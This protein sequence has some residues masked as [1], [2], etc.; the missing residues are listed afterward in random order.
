MATKRKTSLKKWICTV[1]NFIDL[2]QFHLIW[3]FFAKLSG[4]ESE[5]KENSCAVFTNSSRRLATTAKKCTKKHDAR[6]KLLLC[7]YKP[8]AFLPFSLPSTSL[9]L[10]LPIVV[11]QK[12]CYHGNVTSH[13]S[14]LALRICSHF[15]TIVPRARM[16]S[17]SIAIDSEAMRARGIIYCFSKI[18]LVGQ[19]YRDKTTLAS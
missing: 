4:V 19:K 1:S 13:F 3:K 15:L 14:L 16:A 10:K 8:I 18:Q 11:I 17:Q 7:W 5:I 12:C 6:A 2:I 9:L